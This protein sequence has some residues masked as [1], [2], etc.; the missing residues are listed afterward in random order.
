METVEQKIRRVVSET[1]TVVP[2]DSQWPEMFR[3]EKEHLLSCL[4]NSLIR[5]IEHF[6]STAIPGAAAKPIVDMLVETTDLEETKRRIVP[7]LESQKYDYFWRPTQE[8]EAIFYAW[9]I[10]RDAQGDRTHH[11][12]MVGP[13]SDLWDRLLFRDYLIDHP[14]VAREYRHLKLDLANR[15]GDDRVAYATAK[16][17]FV[18]RVTN[19]AKEQND[20]ATRRA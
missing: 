17:N 14:D 13:S 3:E 19:Q 1:V 5:R 4:P 15:Y 9:F 12:H 11:I 20:P 8:N 18:N 7:I 10:K 6:G 2:Y 16:A